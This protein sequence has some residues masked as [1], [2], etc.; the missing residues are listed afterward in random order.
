M[1][2]IR[3]YKQSHYK[4]IDNRFLER[5]D[6]SGKAKA[7][8]AYLVSR[9]DDWEVKVDYIINKCFKEGSEWVY[10]ALKELEAFGYISRRRV[11]KEDGKLGGSEYH[12]YE[13][14]Q[15]EHASETIVNIETHPVTEKPEVV[16]LEP[17]AEKP[18]LEK[19]EQVFQEQAI[20]SNKTKQDINKEGHKQTK[21]LS[22]SFSP[23][24]F[25]EGSLTANQLQTVKALVDN[26]A[27]T[28]K[29]EDPE[30]LVQQIAFV[31]LDPRAF[32]KA[33]K[34]FTYKLNSIAK[35]I[36]AGRWEIP[37]AY[38]PEV[39]AKIIDPV[40][41]ECK[42]LK[43]KIH[44]LKNLVYSAESAAKMFADNVELAEYHQHNATVSRQQLTELQTKL[45]EFGASSNGN[46][47]AAA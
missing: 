7:V 45:A 21:E 12:V 34:D 28:Q 22:V 1:S 9:P 2:I 39:K 17:V 23:A 35:V 42:S 4:T 26:L 47:G 11:R 44:Q 13:T 6:L 8:L 33:G 36:R 3:V 14:P 46:L 18:N 41:R 38:S 32:S 40:E 15:N 25:I 37:T 19:P 5:T 24:K 27:K 29:I 20:Y 43:E 10:G 31:L 30:D 16:N